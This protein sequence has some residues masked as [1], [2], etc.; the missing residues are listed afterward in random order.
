MTGAW[1]ASYI[2]LWALVLFLAFLLAGALRQL[3]LV[4]LRMGDDPGALI[5]DS[6][7]D[8]G[9]EAPDF[10]AQSLRTGDSIRL[11]DLPDVARMLV[12]LSPFCMSCEQVVPHLNEVKETW[13]REFDFMV[14]CR[15]DIASCRQFVESTGLRIQNVVVDTTGEVER[16]YEARMT[17]FAYLLDYQGRVLIRGVANNWMQLESLLN[18]EGTL[19]RGRGWTATPER[20]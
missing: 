15:G 18:Q 19:E 17:P 2:V 11:S 4:Q 13:G 8:R 20:S 5:T 6:G 10:V 3:G 7:L 12:F 9:T 14:V 16:L 1:V